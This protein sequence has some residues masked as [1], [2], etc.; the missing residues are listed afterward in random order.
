MANDPGVNYWNWLAPRYAR[1][2]LRDEA[3]FARSLAIC[4]P[5]V[6]GRDVLELGAGTGTTALRLAPLSRNYLAT[7]YADRMIGI[8]KVRLDA[9]PV[10]QL[11]LKRASIASLLGTDGPFDTVLAFNLLHLLPDLEDALRAIH[12]VLR[13][14]GVFISKTVCLR[15]APPL[16]RLALPFL[17]FVRIAPRMGALSEAD[18]RAAISNAGF[19]IRAVEYH[20]SRGADFRPVIRAQ[21]G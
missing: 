16:I 2:V 15:A 8:A 11:R 3:G 13:P 18:L 6:T 14:G 21:R 5:H 7:D 20:A 19:E 4:A 10:A 12:Q 9:A 1:M 17:R